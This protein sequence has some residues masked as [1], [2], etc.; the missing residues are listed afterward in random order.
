[1][2]IHIKQFELISLT[3]IFFRTTLCN[4]NLS[5]VYNKEGNANNDVER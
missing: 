5:I 3:N 1:M 4:Q 2:Y